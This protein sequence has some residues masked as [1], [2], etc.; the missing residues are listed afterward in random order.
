MPAAAY[1]AYVRSN[2][3]NTVEPRSRASGSLGAA[4]AAGRTEVLGEPAY[5]S[6]AEAPGD[7]HT[8]HET[9]AI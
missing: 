9:I 2:T 3:G 1:G 6:L 5:P 7:I 8:V 4:L